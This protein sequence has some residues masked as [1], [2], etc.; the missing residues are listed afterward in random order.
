MKNNPYHFRNKKEFNEAV[1][2]KFK[3]LINA[4]IEKYH[5]NLEQAKIKSTKEALIL[6]LPIACTAIH[7]AYGFAEKRQEKFIE[8]FTTHMQCIN[9]GITDIQQY[10]DWCIENKIKY[11]EVVEIEDE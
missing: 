9:D 3:P 6:L 2:K 7:E 11:F 8:Y 5:N 10:K 1:N 4:E